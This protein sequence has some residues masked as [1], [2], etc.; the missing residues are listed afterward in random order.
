MSDLQNGMLVQHASLG[1][2]KVIA[3]EEKAVHVYFA[4]SDARFATK[5]R[6]PM[7][8]PDNCIASVSGSLDRSGKVVVAI[9]AG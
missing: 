8:H 3:L 4:S 2:G 7:A 6:L 5:L 1:L 9:L